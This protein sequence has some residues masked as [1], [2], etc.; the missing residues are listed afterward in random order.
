MNSKDSVEKL[1]SQRIDCDL[2]KVC[3]D[4]SRGRKLK[5]AIPSSRRRADF[6]V[7]RPRNAVA[8]PDAGKGSTRRFFD[9]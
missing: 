4:L 6:L 5:T 1:E 3:D 8:L 2:E 7:C 9:R